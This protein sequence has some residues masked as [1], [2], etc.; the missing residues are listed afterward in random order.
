MKPLCCAGV[1]LRVVT[2]RPIL[3]REERRGEREKRE[4]VGETNEVGRE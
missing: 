1:W 4:K 3:G 2:G